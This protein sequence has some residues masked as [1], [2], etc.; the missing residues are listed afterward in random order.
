[1]AH[2]IEMTAFG[3]ASTRQKKERN[4][5]KK[6][7]P[8]EQTNTTVKQRVSRHRNTIASII[9][10][11]AL[12]HSSYHRDVIYLTYRGFFLSSKASKCLRI[13]ADGKPLELPTEMPGVTFNVDDQCRQ[14]YGNR[15][16]HCPKYKVFPPLPHLPSPPPG[17][18]FLLFIS[19]VSMTV[20]TIGEN[21][22]RI[23]TKG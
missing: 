11:A 18:D 9:R 22:D 8:S 7:E 20:C 4:E 14:Q 3:K 17:E 15:A 19:L 23:R 12:S 16:R 6:K 2:L 1:M 5:S 21:A 10:I 13:H